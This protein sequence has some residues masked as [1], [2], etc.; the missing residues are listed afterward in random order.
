MSQTIELTPNGNKVQPL[1][2]PFG[3]FC[4]MQERCPHRSNWYIQKDKDYYMCQKYNT[5]LETDVHWISI[6]CEECQNDSY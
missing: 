6:K 3:T 5:E 4:N 1:N 2:V